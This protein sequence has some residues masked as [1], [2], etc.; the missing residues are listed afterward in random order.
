MFVTITNQNYGH[1]SLD[2]PID[3]RGGE[4]SVAIREIFY[5]INWTNI[6]EARGNNWI[7]IPGDIRRTIKDGYYNLCTLSETLFQP[8]GIKSKLDLA[9]M[10]VTLTMAP[11]KG[12]T[13][14]SELLAEQLGFKQGHFRTSENNGVSYTARREI[15][16]TVN[17]MLYIHLGQLSTSDNLLNGKPSQIL[18]V[19]PASKASYCETENVSFTGLQFKKLECGYF[20]SLNI[21]IRNAKEHTVTVGNLVIVL[22]IK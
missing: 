16:L 11:G 19:I 8:Y 15:D 3:N 20:E 17:R 6:S 1:V 9:T 18:R 5:S 2:T 14:M 21:E 4:K 13:K 7:Q 12:I 22:E 10:R